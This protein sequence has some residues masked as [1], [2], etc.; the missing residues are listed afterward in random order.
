MSRL[1]PL[2][3]LLALASPARAQEEE[4]PSTPAPAPP[5]ALSP[6]GSGP[7]PRERTAREAWLRARLDGIIAARPELG[8]ARLGIAVIEVTTGKKLYERNAAARLKL[9]SNAKVI[10][11]AGA[12]SLLGP[13]YRYRTTFY[14]DP[15][16]ADGTIK[17]HLWLRGAGDPSLDTAALWALVRELRLLGVKKVTGGLY[18]DDSAF[19]AAVL[20]PVFDEKKEDAY[21][22]APV[23]A[24]SLN[25]SAVTV[26]VQ[27]GAAAGAPARVTVDPMSEY[28]V[29][30]SAATTI[31]AGRGALA[32]AAT[33]VP[34]AEQMRITVSGTIRLDAVG[35]EAVKKRIEHPT[36]YLGATLRALLAR[37]GI[38]IAQKGV[39]R[40]V[41]PAG[42]RALASRRSLPVGVLVRE[43]SKTSNNFMAE[44]LL[45]TI[46]L[47][48]AGPPATWAAGI[49]AVK[50][51]LAE[52]GIPEDA[53]EYRNGSG[54]Y[55]SAFASAETMARILVAAARDFRYGPDFVAALAVAG[56]DGTLGHRMVGGAAERYVRAKSGSLRGVACLAGFAGGVGKP[57]LAFAVLVN[58]APD[59]PSGARASRALADQVAEE[60]VRFI[61]AE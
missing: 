53:Y 46:A 2:A 52:L 17:G 8:A 40:G 33:P 57:L 21:F 61:E 48:A 11:A 20:P 16:A 9:A 36:A 35:G 54:L 19:D 5:A 7:P 34:G 51:R 60:L 50:R 18:V 22:R 42:P 26:W 38:K 29:V 6:Q 1:I 28:L 32:V 23:S 37:E 24:A 58:D 56:A 15:P 4:A 31:A 3:A 30:E 45:K 49:A 39:R 55:S 44:A 47:E 10:T 14:A 41:V 43:M 59:S 27:P 13:E 25:D 12:L